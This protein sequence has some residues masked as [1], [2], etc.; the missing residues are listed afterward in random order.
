[1]A[2]KKEET[3]DEIVEKEDVEE[4]AEVEE[5]VDEEPKEEK[6]K[7]LKEEIKAAVTKAPSTKTHVEVKN[8]TENDIYAG[9]TCIR[10]GTVGAIRIK[11]NEE[12]IAYTE[13]PYEVVRVCIQYSTFSNKYHCWQQA[14]IWCA[15]HEL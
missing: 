14:Q 4:E 2:K 7:E 6:K 8:D 1:M 3:N 11:G 5:T 13:I 10:K 15:P 12:D 9:N